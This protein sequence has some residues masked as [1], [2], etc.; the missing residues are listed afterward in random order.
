MEGNTIILIAS[1]AILAMGIYFEY[2]QK[3]SEKNWNRKYNCIN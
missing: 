1:V 2:K 3:D